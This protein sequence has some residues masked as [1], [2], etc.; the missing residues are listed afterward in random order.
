MK[1]GQELRKKGLNRIGNLIVP[2]E[3]YCKFEDWVTPILDTMLEEQKKNVS[4][5]VLWLTTKQNKYFN[6]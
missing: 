3:N 4:S 2:N 5:S 6:D 1:T